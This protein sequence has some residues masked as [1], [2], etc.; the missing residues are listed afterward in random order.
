PQSL[1]PLSRDEWEQSVQTHLSGTFHLLSQAWPLFLQQ[2][3]GRALTIAPGVRLG[4]GNPP[5]GRATAASGLAGMV[6]ALALEGASHNI[7]VNCVAPPPGEALGLPLGQREGIGVEETICEV[8]AHLVSE[9]ARTNGALM[10]VDAGTLRRVAM[11]RMD[12]G[13]LSLPGRTQQ[14]AHSPRP[15]I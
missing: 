3:Y 2:R 11:V 8:V 13:A 7:M 12:A 14:A 9:A 6:S 5:L 15:G 1:E 4:R 10:E